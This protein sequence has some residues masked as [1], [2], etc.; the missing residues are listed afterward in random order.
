[1]EKINSEVSRSP[2]M[3][4][5]LAVFP[6]ME[7]AYPDEPPILRELLALVNVGVEPVKAA[8]EPATAARMNTDFMMVMCIWLCDVYLVYVKCSR[9]RWAALVTNASERDNGRAADGIGRWWLGQLETDEHRS[10]WWVE[11]GT[12]VCVQKWNLDGILFSI[13]NFVSFPWPIR[14]IMDMNFILKT[15]PTT[16]PFFTKKQR[17]RQH[18][19]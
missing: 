2:L 14:I 10:F 18:K 9:C 19:N 16:T 8:A 7:V 1:M 17:Q 13:S 15:T 3:F 5:I 12:D 6:G 4:V 11:E